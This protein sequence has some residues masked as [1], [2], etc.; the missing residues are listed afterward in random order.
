[1]TR[2][3]LRSRQKVLSREK[4]GASM[5]RRLV[6]VL[7]AAVLAAS[8]SSVLAPG[9]AASAAPPRAF[10]GHLS[11]P[12]PDGMVGIRL[13]PR[14][15][16]VGVGL[17]LTFHVWAVSAD[18]KDLTEVADSVTVTLD[19]T[20]CVASTCTPTRAG[21]HRV[22]AILYSGDYPL[23]SD[24]IDFEA[25]DVDG[26][27]LEPRRVSRQPGGAVSYQ[28]HA[29]A[30]WVDVRAGPGKIDLGDVTTVTAFEVAG[31]PCDGSECRAPTREGTYKVSGA[32]RPVQR[33]PVSGVAELDVEHGSPRSM[34]LEPGAAT[35]AV[36]KA[37]TYRA[38]ADDGFGNRFDVS[39]V[40]SFAAGPDVW[41]TG[42]V[43]T[44]RKPGRYTVTAAVG[45]KP[46]VTA[47][48]TLVAEQLRPA[49][50]R[51][52]PGTA[53]IVVG[54]SQPYR[55]FGIGPGGRRLGEVTARTVFT[56]DKGGS[57]DRRGCG[58]REPGTYTVTGELA[59]DPEVTGTATLTVLPRPA[60]SVR[61][62]PQR[63][64][65]VAGAMQTYRA[66]AL[67]DRGREVGDVTGKVM[68][69]IVDTSRL[70]QVGSC[71][72]PRCGAG[73]A[74]TYRV[75]GR[76]PG[77]R[78][79]G[80]AELTVV[81]APLA[82]LALA[83]PAASIV[84][85][86]TQA[87]TVAGFDAAG[88]S[89][90]ELTGRA[91]F[92]IRP[93][94]SC[95]EA[96]CT[97]DKAGGY[98][99]AASVVDE[100]TGAT[101]TGTA[102]LRVDPAELAAVRLSPASAGVLAGADQAYTA[103]GF[104]AYGNVSGDVTART[105]FTIDAG[106]ECAGPSCSAAR[107]GPYTVTGTVTG[108]DVVGGAVSG[109]S[110]L[111]VTPAPPARLVLEPQQTTVGTGGSQAYTAHG[112]DA[113]G[114]DVG[115]VT[116]Q[117]TF[118]IS[119]PGSC[120]AATCSG[121]E[122][123][124]Y[125]VTGQLAGLDVRGEARLTVM[126]AML[127]RLELDPP[128]RTVAPGAE[129]AYRARGYDAFGVSLGDV[130]R[131]TVFSIDGGRCAGA[132][133]SAEQAGDHL[134]TGRVVGTDATG[135]AR[136]RVEATGPPTVAGLVLTPAVS[137]V[138]VGAVQTYSARGLDAGGSDRGDVTGRTAFSIEP[139]GW[140]DGSACRADRAGQHRVVGV[141][142][143]TGVRQTA[144][145][146]VTQTT[147]ARL[148]LDPPT[149]SVGVR[150]VQ[151]YRARAFDAV[152]NDLGDVSDRVILQTTD[153]GSCVGLACGASKPGR[154]GVTAVPLGGGP[155]GRATLTVTAA[156]PVAL[157][158]SPTSASVVQ[159]TT[160]AY[161]SRGLDAAGNDLGDMTAR[162]EFTI[163]PGGSCAAAVCT[164][165]D[166][167]D[168]TVTGTISG[169]AVSASATLRAVALATVD[170]SSKTGGP[171]W[172]LLLGGGF[173]LA[174]AARSAV[175]RIRQGLGRPHDEPAGSTADARDEDW[176]RRNVRAQPHPGPVS[177]AARRRERRPDLV[178]HLEAH[179]DPNGTQTVEENPSWR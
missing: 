44:P 5:A 33:P 18:G 161:Q 157:V 163:A 86:A 160:Q 143:G 78:G 93:G 119:S 92:S 53:S 47:T 10:Q 107:T 58:A 41:C 73:S 25:L 177:S 9:P 89:L 134:V 172:V 48:A 102:A 56:I 101:V 83:P 165:R 11:A 21:S 32:V 140:C 13:T 55:A 158:L 39:T 23:Y 120:R 85:G 176:V 27:D 150:G 72:G 59:D 97:S 166:P 71:D 139:D 148:L 65:V 43:C 116:A 167:G 88:R 74:G 123:A 90:G 124:T 144:R 149:A 24:S 6:P 96:R 117:T 153:G 155:V 67:D 141:L 118:S 174:A 99:V 133:C 80:T 84:A 108:A 75:T 94:G 162:T 87:Y 28:A 121:R 70:G 81:S 66:T 115:D 19:Q 130:T 126:P 2:M 136:L 111:R 38:T 128:Q 30:K 15:E 82:R 112:Y 129:Q 64:R 57:C 109:T 60:V 45:E 105:T 52:R 169:T 31:V 91:T 46:R 142:T 8:G 7:L 132:V 4:E 138:S 127:A 152:G 168:Y 63:A 79:T 170:E 1:M 145:L 103:L 173:L 76:V 178:L 3:A 171:D 125:T 49:E 95:T 69:S 114:N 34:T 40:A 146:D 42:P 104:D 135:T 175:R 77:I 113:L 68:L 164:V 12:L 137:S 50:L 131:R 20:G 151:S 14:P 100:E 154:Y 54:A 110:S 61:L 22:T 106:G 17:P 156:E 35:V 37:L 122:P 147:P 26:L 16:R 62:D 179:A 51:L 36:G 98:T 29:Y 159:R